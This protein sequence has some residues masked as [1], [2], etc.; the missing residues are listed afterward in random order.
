MAFCTSSYVTFSTINPGLAGASLRLDIFDTPVG[1]VLPGSD[2]SLLR[3]FSTDVTR[4]SN[5]AITFFPADGL[6]G[7]PP[8][9]NYFSGTR[10]EVP[11]PFETNPPVSVGLHWQSADF[12]T[13]FDVTIS[14]PTAGNQTLS[15]C[16]LLGSLAITLTGALGSGPGPLVFSIVA[17]PSHG[18]L[19]PLVGAAV[20]YTQT[21]GYTGADSFIFK[22]NDGANDS[23]VG[24]ISLTVAAASWWSLPN[25][26]KQN[27]CAQPACTMYPYDITF[28]GVVYPAGTCMP[29][30]V[31]TSPVGNASYCQATDG[32]WYHGACPIIPRQWRLEQFTIKP[33]NESSS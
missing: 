11:D 16:E 2:A 25:G 9:V 10:V 12:L 28:G 21:P 1:C 24:T 29:W 30:T 20:T 6:H 17:G 32:S 14:L 26:T 4:V 33:R 7:G 22:T 8:L 31:S 13:T 27:A 19:G 5:G 23:P 18:T 3:R 15:Y